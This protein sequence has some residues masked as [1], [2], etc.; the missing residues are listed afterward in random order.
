MEDWNFSWA[1]NAFSSFS[2]SL[3]V[4]EIVLFDEINHLLSSFLERLV[5]NIKSGKGALYPNVREVM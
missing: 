5:E 3:P 4:R 1:S 2:W